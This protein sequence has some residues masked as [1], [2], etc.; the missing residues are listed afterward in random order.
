MT[1]FSLI[2]LLETTIGVLIILM[3]QALVMVLLSKFK[4]RVFR[5]MFSS[6]TS[7][8]D[9][10]QP[11]TS[12]PLHTCAVLTDD[13]EAFRAGAVDFDA[14]PAHAFR[15]RLRDSAHTRNSEVMLPASAP[16]SGLSELAPTCAIPLT[17]LIPSVPMPSAPPTPSASMPLVCRL[18]HVMR[19]GFLLLGLLFRS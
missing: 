11:D 8:G 3:I 2:T 14:A 9:I 12:Y 7:T 5:L 13:T 15:S 17:L 19:T 4:F 6:A 18:L 16:P 1:F 10:P